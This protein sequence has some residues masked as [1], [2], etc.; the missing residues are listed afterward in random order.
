MLDMPYYEETAQTPVIVNNVQVYEGSNYYMGKLVPVSTIKFINREEQDVSKNNGFIDTNNKNTEKKINQFVEQLEK[1]TRT[2]VYFQTDKAQLNANDFKQLENLADY[3][4]VKVK[5]YADPRGTVVYNDK[6]SKERA[7]FVADWLS[8][9]GIQVNK[10]EYFGE[11]KP[12]STY[13]NEYSLDRRVELE[14][15]INE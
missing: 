15:K 12:I 14:L 11:N 3:G 10:V 4:S 7:Y 6:L 2:I 8:K 13:Q 1:S 9:R 5:G